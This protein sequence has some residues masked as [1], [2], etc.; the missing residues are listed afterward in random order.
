MQSL[1]LVA[2]SCAGTRGHAAAARQASKHSSK[3]L[4]GAKRKQSQ[5]SSSSAKRLER[6]KSNTW[7]GG[8]P[9]HHGAAPQANG[10]EASQ[11]LATM[12]LYKGKS[13][14]VQ[15]LR[16]L[17]QKPA[18]NLCVNACRCGQHAIG[19]ATTTTTTK[20]TWR[21]VSG[22]QPGRGAPGARKQ[23]SARKKV[24]Q[25]R[26]SARARTGRSSEGLTLREEAPR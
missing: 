13:S 20:R 22:L 10:A 23:A 11:G 24:S 14:S 2:P 12:K 16:E 26:K 7:Q 4:L 5:Q 15:C 17:E 19:H 3:A 1:S 25:R 9:Q 8:S 18:K 21:A 6:W